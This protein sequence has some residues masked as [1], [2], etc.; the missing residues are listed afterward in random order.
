[1][2]VLRSQHHG[3]PMVSRDGFQKSISFPRRCFAA[4][5]G[6]QSCMKICLVFFVF[7]VFIACD[8][9]EPQTL[10]EPAPVATPAPEREP[11]RVVTYTEHLRPVLT[12]RCVGCHYEGG[13]TPFALETYAQSRPW[14]MAMASAVQARRMPP[15]L[16]D[17][18]GDC[19]S[20]QDSG[21]LGQEEIDLFEAWVQSGT[22][23]GDRTIE[24]PSPR[25]QPQLTGPLQRVDIGADYLPDQSKTDDYR[26]FVVESPGDFG[27]SGF[28]V[29]PGNPRIVH[30]LIAYQAANEAA[31]QEAR[32][33]DLESPEPGYDCL[34]TGP[35]VEAGSLAGWAPGTGPQIF[36]EGI[37]IDI[38]RDRPLI[39]EVHYNIAGGPGETDRTTLALQTVAQGTVRP[40][41]ELAAIDYDFVAP[42]GEAFYSTTDD[43]PVSWQ[44]EELG[45][46][47]VER[48]SRFRVLSA[49]A[50]MHQRGISQRIERVGANGEVECLLHVPRWDFDWQLN[51]WYDVPVEISSDDTLRITCAFDTRGAEG[52]VTW[53]EGT[54]EEMCL[55]SV[56]V[57]QEE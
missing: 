35:G 22:P 5:K 55:G 52:P 20:F 45:V 25:R 8:D 54:K 6:I 37:G 15:Y 23:E 29:T 42:A 19:Q 3:R 38:Y 18:S 48:P 51:Y 49:N 10:V 46:V 41:L 13:S 47:P 7:F 53:G 2:V 16:A 40:M 28:E 9:S 24:A 34:G 43:F 56:L 44:L 31:A 11:E 39:L 50:H 57:V 33:L 4:Q 12:R 27:V 26:C 14:A 32:R 21:W 17:D 1:M 30:H 36:P